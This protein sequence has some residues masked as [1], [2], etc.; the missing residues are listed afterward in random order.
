[1]LIIVGLYVVKMAIIVNGKQVDDSGMNITYTAACNER[2]REIIQE[3]EIQQ[4]AR[5]HTFH[6]SPEKKYSCPPIKTN[7]DVKS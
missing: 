5:V 3:S 1:M 4:Q 7:F 2:F 6:D